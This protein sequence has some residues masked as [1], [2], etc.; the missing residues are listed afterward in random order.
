MKKLM[1]VISFFICAFANAENFQTGKVIGYI[2][3]DFQGK[4]LFFVQIEGNATGGCNTTS[5][6]VI[7]S[8]QPKFKS[9]R[10]AIMASFY[11]QVPIVAV[12]NQTGNTFPNSWDLLYVCVGPIPC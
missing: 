9:V 2:P 7:D 3:S 8:S 4:E 11:S 10:A 1:A 12:Y 5:R 6:F